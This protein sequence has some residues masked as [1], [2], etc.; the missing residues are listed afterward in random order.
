[1]KR[2]K[3]VT[4]EAFF[5]NT[6]AKVYG[7]HLLFFFYKAY[8]LIF[9]LLFKSIYIFNLFFYNSPNKRKIFQVHLGK[10]K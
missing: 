3:P 6:T 8:P 9:I 4:G 5:Y 10:G 1:M 7:C 2:T